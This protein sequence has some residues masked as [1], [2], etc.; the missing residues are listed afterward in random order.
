MPSCS[1]PRPMTFLHV[2]QEEYLTFERDLTGEQPAQL[3]ASLEQHLA[4]HGYE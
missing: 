1:N 3:G 2:L 4:R